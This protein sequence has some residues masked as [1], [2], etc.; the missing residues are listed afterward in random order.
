MM[1]FENAWVIFPLAATCK[2][3]PAGH[4]RAQCSVLSGSSRPVT[5]G[6]MQSAGSCRLACDSS[7]V[8]GAGSCRP[9]C[10]DSRV[11]GGRV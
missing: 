4:S 11:H 1:P 5:T 10:G 9:A 7:R 2:S 3:R 8:Q 6:R